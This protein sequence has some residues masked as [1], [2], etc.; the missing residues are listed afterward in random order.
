MPQQ[1][2]KKAVLATVN[3]A[4]YEFPGLKLPDGRYA[5]LY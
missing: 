3:Y 4:G 2:P 1:K 5:I